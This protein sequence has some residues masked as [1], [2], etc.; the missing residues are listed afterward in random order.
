MNPFD[1]KDKP[2]QIDWSDLDR[3]NLLSSK[4]SDAI[5]VK[6]SKGHEPS[7]VIPTSKHLENNPRKFALRTRR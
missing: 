6:R 4:V 2:S 7:I 5:S 1:W 3:A